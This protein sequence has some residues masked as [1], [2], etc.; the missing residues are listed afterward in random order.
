DA[1]PIG[2]GAGAPRR[3]RPQWK[4]WRAAPP[5]VPHQP[6]LMR[7]GQRPQ[8]EEN[9]QQPAGD[10]HAALAQQGGQP[11][12]RQAGGQQHRPGA[13]AEGQHQQRAVQ[14]IALAG[15]PQQGAVHQPA[16]QPAPQGAQG[17]GLGKSAH[18][19]E[20]LGDGLDEA[21]QPLAQRLDAR[22]AAPPAGQ[23]QAHGDQ[24][25]GGDDAQDGG[26]R[27]V[28]QR[29]AAQAEQQAGGGIAENA[30]QVVAQQQAQAAPPLFRRNGQGQRAH[31]AAA[32]AQAM[33]AA[34]QAEDEG[35]NQL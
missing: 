33:A 29:P 19:H 20:A 24:Q 22:Q 11:L 27:A 34:Q 32:H 6:V 25:Q 35:G 9:H 21:P 2:G 23:V 1:L 28:G 4:A 5:S 31:Q 30:P 26:R 7:P 14:R 15:G 13:Q 17:D 8:A 12:G 16:G 18:R 3:I 10:A